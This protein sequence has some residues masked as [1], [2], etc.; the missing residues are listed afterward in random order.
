M[1]YLNALVVI[2]LCVAAASNLLG[3]SP[4]RRPAGMQPVAKPATST[5]TPTPAPPAV[6]PAE[7]LS[8]QPI[9][10]VNGQSI[11]VA[12][13]EPAVRQ[14]V[15]QLGQRMAEL[16]REVLDLQINT[17][18]LDLEAKKRKLSSQQLYDADVTKRV[19]EPTEV[20]IKQ[21]I[22]ANR[23]ELA[24]KDPQSIRADVIALMRGD[25]EQK[26]AGE[27]VTR[28]RA[29]TPATPGADINNPNLNQ[30]TVIATVGGQQLTA[31]VFIERLKPIIYKLRLDTYQLERAALERTIDD[32][33][34]I[35]EANKRSVGPESIVRTEITDKIRRPTETEVAKFFTDNKAKITGD[36]PAVHDQIA[37]YLQQQQQSDLER[38]LS[39]RLRKGANLQ[40]L[41][42]PPE[43]PVQLINMTGEPTRGDANAAVTVVE[44]TDFECPACGAMQPVLEDVL[45]A[46]GNRVRFVVRNFPLQR[47]AHA[48][49][50]AEAADA[51][52]A[53]G[54]FFEYTALLFKR[55]NALD[56]PSL[57]KYATELGLNRARFDA[58]LDGGTHAADVKHDNDEGQ[59]YGV[60]VTPSIFVNGIRLTELSAEGLK[61]AID[62][63]FARAGVR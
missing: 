8:T 23:D 57:K 22:E 27:L 17:V 36:L 3:Q 50:A 42:T 48:Q 52:H 33:L 53:Q 16:R 40:I 49:K 18:L 11:T 30:A 59:I 58:E 38:G 9:A 43:P 10:I 1:R 26:L 15:E 35:A 56:I 20:E 7:P 5:P 32:V 62:K 19:S 51:A 41:L 6:I 24:G 46:Y 21:F 29:A 14:E 4:R 60:D 45:K 34:L 31:A 39:E 13:I 61:A 44:F 55:Q 12:D 54:K 25:R 2:T 28:L 37:N 47:H 63:A